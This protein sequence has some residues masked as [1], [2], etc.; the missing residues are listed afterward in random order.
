M[1]VVPRRPTRIH[2]LQDT[3]KEENAAME[4]Y[5]YAQIKVNRRHAEDS[6]GSHVHLPW[7]R[8]QESEL[9]TNVSRTKWQRLPQALG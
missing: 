1:S 4:T 8:M 6:G 7:R 5:A 2:Q 3:A 9:P